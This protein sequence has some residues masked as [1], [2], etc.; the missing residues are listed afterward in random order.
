MY[1]RTILLGLAA[2]GFAS[3]LAVRAMDL[4]LSHTF[5]NETVGQHVPQGWAPFS[6]VNPS[7]A[8]IVETAAP[9]SGTLS[10]K[11]AGGGTTNAGIISPRI[12][13]DPGR[14]LTISAWIKASGTGSGGAGAYFSIF[15]YDAAGNPVARREGS[16]NTMNYRHIGIHSG[17]N[18]KK[19]S[20]TFVPESILESGYP[21]PAA[22]ERCEVRLFRFYD[23]PLD[24]W[25]D[26]VVV[27]QG[28]GNLLTSFEFGADTP[29]Q[30]QTTGSFGTAGSVTWSGTT[31]NI[32]AADF[33]A[34]LKKVIGKTDLGAGSGPPVTI[35]LH[36]SA[37]DWHELPPAE[38]ADLSNIDK[39]EIIADASSRT[40]TIKGAT[41]LATSYGTMAFFQRHLNAFWAMPGDLGE[42]FSNLTSFQIPDGT[43]E[44]AP[45]AISRLATGVR[46]N[47]PGKV[48]RGQ[49]E[50][51]IT[52]FNQ[53]HFNAYDF[54]KSWRMHSFASPSHNMINILP[55]ELQSDNAWWPIFPVETISPL[56]YYFPPLAPADPRQKQ[57]WHPNYTQSL[58]EERITNVAMD[59]FS[60]TRSRYATSGPLNPP[61]QFCF[62]I[63]IN[64]GAKT[65][66]SK[67]EV[68]LSDGVAKTY[69]DMVTRIGNAVKNAEDG[70][71]N[72]LYPGRLLG[73]LAYSDVSQPPAGLASLPDNVL[74]LSA[75]PIPEPW[76]GKASHLGA[77]EYFFGQG[78][79][80]PYF[81]LAAMKENSSF[82]EENNF[83]FFRGEWHPLWAFDAPKNFLR[84]R[85]FWN[86]DYDCDAGLKEYCRRAF[87]SGALEMDAMYRRWAEKQDG[88][89]DEGS[90]TRLF[91]DWRKVFAQFRKWCSEEDLD[92]TDGH[93]LNAK[94]AVTAEKDAAGSGTRAHANAEAALDRLEMVEAFFRD[95][96]TLYGM[97]DAANE[98]FNR[99]A[100]GDAAERAEQ[101]GLLNEE[102]QD[103]LEEIYDQQ[104][105]WLAGTSA[106]IALTGST[107]VPNWEPSSTIMPLPKLMPAVRMTEAFRVNPQT[108]GQPLP[109]AWNAPAFP[110]LQQYL[111][112]YA[113]TQRAMKIYL[114][115]NWPAQHSGWF[116]V[117]HANP[118]VSSFNATRT[119]W[120]FSTD[121]TKIG[122][123]VPEGDY[124]EGT[125]KYQGWFTVTLQTVPGVPQLLELEFSGIDGDFILDAWNLETDAVVFETFGPVETTVHKRVL[126]IP[127]FSGSGNFN[128]TYRV[129][130]YPKNANSRLNNGKMTVK[131]VAF[132]P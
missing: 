33:A 23:Y 63:G 106:Q 101:A 121:N 10:L 1:H 41:A 8:E 59:A 119:E 93:I 84:T 103:G 110:D 45:F 79:W 80:M 22:A 116:P 86:P 27:D 25:Y 69:Y 118:L 46:T 49:A 128:V 5:E 102:R 34:S 120:Y 90:V 68:T 96:R 61:K 29:I 60:G 83:R 31:Q 32:V 132:Q 107:Y 109:S 12:P 117:S 56:T 130:W 50:G 16:P 48:N 55:A 39:Y 44:E 85:Q 127:K 70:G 36:S 92:A 126:F 6:S 105:V 20:Y 114:T 13:V 17:T 108:S 124:D 47:E 89:V 2:F 43:F 28:S 24:S 14:S 21:V 95:T 51:G 7:R 82:Y 129:Y 18:W 54:F 78:Y 115:S 113:A 9:V 123:T 75:S 88:A 37:A 35:V 74:V 94:T 99:D 87:G 58:T 112:P 4:T 62:S 77:Y 71:G 66:P 100:A 19:V 104:S 111:Q 40:I 26:D 53:A 65:H 91:P 73:V 98:S 38:L 81:P 30:I 64:D 125:L 72:P 52:D 97:Y 76:I 15:W 11:I 67:D 57:N 131:N 3:P 122:E 42:C